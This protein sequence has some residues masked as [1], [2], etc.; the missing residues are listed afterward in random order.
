MK[1]ALRQDGEVRARAFWQQNETAVEE[2][3][4]EIESELEQLRAET[5]RSLQAEEAAL[6]NKLLFAARA[7]A[8]GCRLH[9]EA[10]MEVRLQ[11]LAGGVLCELAAADR[12]GP[13]HVEAFA[14]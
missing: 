4:R 3:R 13:V 12:A 10:A 8:T 14:Q 6:R 11:E 2:R 5:G 9:A 1:T 7:R